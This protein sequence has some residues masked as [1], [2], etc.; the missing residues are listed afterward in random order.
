[1]STASGPV[2]S[3]ERVDLLDILRGLAIFGVFVMIMD[4]RTNDESKLYAEVLSFILANKALSLLSMLFGIGFGLQMARAGGSGVWVFVWRMAVLFL[5][6]AAHAVL[7]FG[8]TILIPYAIIGC[9]LLL[10][11]RLTIRPLLAIACLLMVPLQFQRS[12]LQAVPS[13]LGEDSARVKAEQ[14]ARQDLRKELDRARQ[15]GTYGKVVSLQA[16][17]FVF[18]YSGAVP[19]VTAVFPAYFLPMAVLGLAIAK[20]RLVREY[21]ERRRFL[22]AVMWISLAAGLSSN[23]FSYLSLGGLKLPNEFYRFTFL[24]SGPTLAL[25]YA[26]SVTLAVETGVGQRLLGWLRWPGRMTMTN[27]VLVTAI[28]TFLYNGY[29]FGLHQKVS[30]PQ[31]LVLAITFFAALSFAS[32]VWLRRFPLGPLEWLWRT[33]T[34][35]VGAANRRESRNERLAVDCGG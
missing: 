23:P 8:D 10:L 31:G 20:S 9:T 22:K 2:S 24:L 16:Q 6:G 35:A 27:Y 17:A 26:C 18:R 34:Y 21:R 7:I 13:V 11:R 33:L 32:Y 12:I 1:M 19:W 29:G 25:F 28:A 14:Q 30:T 4:S 3:S 15:S 5:I